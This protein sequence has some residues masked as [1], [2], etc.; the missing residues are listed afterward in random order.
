MIQDN[1]SPKE[2]LAVNLGPARDNPISQQP[3]F[4]NQS[5]LPNSLGTVQYLIVYVSIMFTKVTQLFCI[6]H[7]KLTTIN[8]KIEK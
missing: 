1:I 6:L 3:N 2:V 8:P 7:H 4:K 5:L